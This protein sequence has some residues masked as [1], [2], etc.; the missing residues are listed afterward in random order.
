MAQLEVDERMLFVHAAQ[1]AFLIELL[2]RGT[3]YFTGSI[4]VLLAARILRYGATSIRS[5]ER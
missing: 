1:L 4:V 5:S 3:G 2:V